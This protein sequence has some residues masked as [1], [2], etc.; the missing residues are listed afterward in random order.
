MGKEISV[1]TASGTKLY[2]ISESGSHYYCYKMSG[3]LFGSWVS[4]GQARSFE[5][6][7]SV[8]KSDAHSKYGHIYGLKIG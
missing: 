4:I 3:S 8:I 5:D 6:G 1:K 2:K 7:L